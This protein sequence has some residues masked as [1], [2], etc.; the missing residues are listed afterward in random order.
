MQRERDTD[1]EPAAPEAG[2]R[3][4]ITGRCSG[5]NRDYVVKI[6][7]TGSNNV[8]IRQ[9]RAN[10]DMRPMDWRPRNTRTSSTASDG[11]PGAGPRRRETCEGA[12]N[13]VV[14]LLLVAKG[15][16][17]EPQEDVVTDS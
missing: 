16:D 3:C 7:D 11:E 2:G 9:Y 1:A 5:W 15:T 17:G 8:T 14:I 4:G 10:R 13:R 6:R 12:K